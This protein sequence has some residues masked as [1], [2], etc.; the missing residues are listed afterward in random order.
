MPITQI[1]ILGLVVAG[2]AIFMIT[3]VSV[4]TYVSIGKKEPALTRSVTPARR[5][6]ETA[7]ASLRPRNVGGPRGPLSNAS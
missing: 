1:M 5:V 3:L 4:S 6:G 2:F 7:T